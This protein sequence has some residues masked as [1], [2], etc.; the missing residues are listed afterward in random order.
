MKPTIATV[1]DP[2]GDPDI[3]TN[4]DVI[5]C[6]LPGWAGMCRQLTEIPI[7]TR[8]H[9]LALLSGEHARLKEGLGVV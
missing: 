6:G 1:L 4:V 9:H 5:A 7:R 8:V 2:D 3:A